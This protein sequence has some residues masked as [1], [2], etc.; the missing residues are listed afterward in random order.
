MTSVCKH[1]RFDVL[2]QVTRGRDFRSPYFPAELLAQLPSKF[3]FKLNFLLSSREEE[4]KI[5]RRNKLEVIEMMCTC[6]P[7]TVPY[8]TISFHTIP[9]HG[10]PCHRLIDL[11]YFVFVIS[12]CKY[13]P[14][15]WYSSY[16]QWWKSCIYTVAYTQGPETI[17]PKY[18]I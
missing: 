11:I 13:L 7:T 12:L 4:G 16:R 6:Y 14:I 2:K 10:M 15:W 18:M 5:Q 3:S 1:I 9:H 17:A 8:H